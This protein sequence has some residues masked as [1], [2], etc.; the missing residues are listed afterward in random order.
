MAVSDL[1][2]KITNK[3]TRVLE[4]TDTE[5][6][7]F[8]L[9]TSEFHQFVVRGLASGVI[10]LQGAI[11]E[12]RLWLP[13]HEIETSDLLT[14]GNGLVSFTLGPDYYRLVVASAGPEV[15]ART[16]VGR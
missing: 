2:L 7:V 4:T 5:S 3:W 8:R 9:G 15:W 13:L 11:T 10:T 16:T 6:I 14:G 1:P 12:A